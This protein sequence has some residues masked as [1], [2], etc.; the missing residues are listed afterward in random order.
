MLSELLGYPGVPM[1]Y[2]GLV[3]EKARS[4]GRGVAGGGDN[5]ESK[6]RQVSPTSDT[7]TYIYLLL[8]LQ[9]NIA[10]DNGQFVDVLFR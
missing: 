8:L 6:Q 7:Y 10:I 9:T 2:H 5:N 3:T 1:T 4:D